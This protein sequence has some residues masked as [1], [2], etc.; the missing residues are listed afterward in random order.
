[1]AEVKNVLLAVVVIGL[2]GAAIY[3][4]VKSPESNWRAEVARLEQTAEAHATA[5]CEDAAALGPLP[6]LAIGRTHNA[7]ELLNA[8][9]AWIIDTVGL[10]DGGTKDITSEDEYAVRDE[11]AARIRARSI[12]EIKDE[13]LLAV[14]STWLDTLDAYDHWELIGNGGPSGLPDFRQLDEVA[15]VHLARAAR[16]G[17]H[18]RAAHAVRQLARLCYSTETLTGALASVRLLGLERMA[19]ENARD[20][21]VSIGEVQPLS[22]AD[23]GRLNRVLDRAPLLAFA[24]TSDPVFSQ[25][26]GCGLTS[27]RCVALSQV[28]SLHA[29]LAPLVES[30][31]RERAE[32]RLA[33]IQKP[34]AECRFTYA[35]SAQQHP[36]AFGQ[37]KYENLPEGTA[38]RWMVGAA[39]A[40]R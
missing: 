13:D 28:A 7:G 6:F 1:M 25:A 40:L 27:A 18:A 39:G 14:D 11:V 17:E 3:W 24:T 8:R 9:V 15:K 33:A 34:D 4:A 22:E 31:W 5:L 36:A 37:R 12:K 26:F 29:R 19:A 21:G 38:G 16:N 35:R 32:R 30:P 2:A 23:T 10:A 20:A